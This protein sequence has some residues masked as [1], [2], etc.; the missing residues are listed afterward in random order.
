MKVLGKPYAY[1]SCCPFCVE[2]LGRRTDPPR[3]KTALSQARALSADLPSYTYVEYGRF[4]RKPW[5]LDGP[6]ATIEA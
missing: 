4:A 2:Q 3:H 5:G 6:R 1:V